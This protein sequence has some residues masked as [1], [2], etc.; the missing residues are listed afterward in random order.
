MI[1]LD[2]GT[3]DLIQHILPAHEVSILAGASGAGKTTLVMQCIQ[4]IQADRPVFGFKASPDL[5]IGYIAADRSWQAYMKLA[6]IAGVDLSK[7]VVRT[8]IDDD[9]IDVSGME[10]KPE[11][12]L[13]QL[14]AFMI[15][16]QCNLIIVDPLIVLLGGDPNKYSSMAPRLIPLNRY[17]RVNHITILGT[18]HAGKARTDFSFKRPQD[19]ISGSAALLGFTSTQLFLSAPEENGTE[20]SEWTIV[21]HHAKAQ[22]IPLTRSDS[23]GLFEIVTQTHIE[24]KQHNMTVSIL[25]VLPAS[26]TPMQRTTILQAIGPTAIERTV[27]RQ[28]SDLVRQGVLAKYD[29]GF[30]GININ[31]RK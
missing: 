20:F 17:C 23:T 13:Y 5:K 16:A 9:S 19:R 25:D 15:Q 30:Y 26:G 31:G 2:L 8:L 27:D 3:P 28:L 4:Q 7:V 1:H 10:K 12:I 11:V 29:G 21:S 18:H 14:L 6:D 24:E 22:T